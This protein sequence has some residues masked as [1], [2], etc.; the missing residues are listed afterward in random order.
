[1]KRQRSYR[2]DGYR[3]D[4]FD[5]NFQPVMMTFKA[6][7][8]TQD[9]SITDVAVQDARVRLGSKELLGCARAELSRIHGFP[10]A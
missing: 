1:M 8:Q 7:L 4:E 10:P 6:F 5:I 9:D 3:R 2:D